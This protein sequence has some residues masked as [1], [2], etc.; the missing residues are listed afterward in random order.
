[1]VDGVS[2]LLRF[3]ESVA[4]PQPIMGFADTVPMDCF[5]TWFFGEVR[6]K[7]PDICGERDLNTRSNKS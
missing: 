1:M 7:N 4:A 2:A 5:Q 6:E 3:A